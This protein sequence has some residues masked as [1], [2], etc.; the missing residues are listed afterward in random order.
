MT[1][2]IISGLPQG[3]LSGEEQAKLASIAYGATANAPDA[4]LRARETHTGVQALASVTGLQAALDAKV[5]AQPGMGLSA[6][7][8]SA[9]EKAKL[10]GL[11]NF[12][13]DC[14]D[15]GSFF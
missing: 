6:H 4:Q 13:L 7:S 8:F 1:R 9:E 15:G 2:L 5:A 12:Q 14:I 3:G 11:E 10:A